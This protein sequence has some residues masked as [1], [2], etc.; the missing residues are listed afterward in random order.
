[1]KIL[2]GKVFGIGNCVMAVPAIRALVSLG[3]EVSILVGTLPD[4]G[5]ATEV[6]GKLG[7]PL[8]QNSVPL[9]NK[10]D[11][12]IMSIPFD[13]RWKNGIH[14]SADKVMDERGRPEYSQV[15]GFSS[16]KKHEAEYQMENPMALGFTGEM[17]SS[18]FLPPNKGDPNKVFIGV[19]YKKDAAGY[20]KQKHWGNENFAEF[21][22]LVCQD[23]K[24][25]VVATGDTQDLIMSLWP[26]E[27]KSRTG[28]LWANKRTLEESFTIIG[29]CGSYVGNDTGMMHVAASL[30][31]PT[32]GLFFLENSLTKT[33]PLGQHA[34][35]AVDRALSPEEVYA[36]WKEIK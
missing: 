4:D 26:I 7:L 11:L 33:K 6:L 8:F 12:A 32:L 28:R 18:S 22:K 25:K 36:K 13:Q 24:M 3:H 20:W 2:F 15:F 17:P 5:G 14:Y 16:W 1:M 27:A 21:I 9:S 34:I 35:E 19:G 30:G 31:K 23:P 10:F 29:D